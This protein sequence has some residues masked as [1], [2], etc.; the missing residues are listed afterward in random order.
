MKISYIINTACGDPRSN[1]PANP[2]RQAGYAERR[3]L[4]TERVLPA[5]LDQGFDEII[6]AGTFEDGAGYTYVP[7]APR[8]RDRRDALWQREIGARHATGDVL[9]FGHDDHAIGEGFVKHL[10]DDLC[11]PLAYEWD[12]LIPRRLHA[13]TGAELNNGRSADYMGGHV[14]VMKRWL[15]AQVP[16]TSVATEFW[17][18]SLTRLWREAGAKL[19]YADDLIHYDVEAAEN[20]S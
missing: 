3:K 7:V 10:H 12:L 16:W 8:Y 17:D 15:W 9:V 19:V 18:L 5:A 6:I 13:I 20:E 1:R 2:W 14:L 11:S 4:L